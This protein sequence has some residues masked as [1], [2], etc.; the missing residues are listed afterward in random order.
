MWK[1][2]KS[3]VIAIKKEHFSMQKS[4]LQPLLLPEN[5]S[6]R[7]KNQ[8]TLGITCTKP[9]FSQSLFFVS[10]IESKSHKK[11]SFSALET[12]RKTITYE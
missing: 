7:H 12:L 10:K 3:P 9:S 6:S 11:K 8:M 4:L 1:S 5:S 2:E